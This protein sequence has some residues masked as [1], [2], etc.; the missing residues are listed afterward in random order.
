M[1]KNKRSRLAILYKE[2]GGICYYCGIKTIRIPSGTSG[3][4]PDNAATIEH[5]Y[6]KFDIR[7]WVQKSNLSNTVMSCNRCN[8][9]RCIRENCKYLLENKRLPKFDIITLIQQK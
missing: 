6:S 2:Q 9:N 1:C 4:L 3:L 7:R 8:K 5:L